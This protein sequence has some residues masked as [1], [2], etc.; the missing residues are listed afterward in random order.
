VLTFMAYTTYP[1]LLLVICLYRQDNRS[2]PKLI[3]LLAFF[4]ASFIAAILLTYTINW[5]VHG[6]FGV[7]LADWRDATPAHNLAELTA[8]LPK[9]VE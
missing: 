4:T 9:L 7:P 2:L 5:S 8:N 6:V 3:A 1:L